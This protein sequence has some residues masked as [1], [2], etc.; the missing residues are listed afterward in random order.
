MGY[1][2]TAGLTPVQAKTLEFVRRCLT[3]RMSPPT[4]DEIATHLQI[5]SRGNVAKTIERLV[6][7]GALVRLP[8]KARSL[9]LPLTT[10][11]PTAFLIDPL[12]EVRL[13]I[14]AYAKAHKISERTAVEEALRAYFVEA[15][16]G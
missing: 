5:K 9:S 8:R 1:P 3:E 4:Y 10:A 16:A 11:A 6:E 7:R 2:M 13:A 14:T 15:A 12:L